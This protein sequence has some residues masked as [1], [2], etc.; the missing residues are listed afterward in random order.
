MLFF[1]L[2]TANS[3]LIFGNLPE[4]FGLVITGIFLI[5]LTFGIRRVF[6][7]KENGK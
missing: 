6:R 7:I 2:Q 3:N 4:S 1:L 5:A